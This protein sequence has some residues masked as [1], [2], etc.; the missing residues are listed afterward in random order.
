MS[1]TVT[2]AAGTRPRS[3]G[4]VTVS[5]SRRGGLALRS[6]VGLAFLA[7]LWAILGWAGALD[8]MVVPTIGATFSDLWTLVG[9]SDFWSALGTTLESTF[10]GLAAGL[11][12]ALPLAVL[13]ADHRWLRRALMPTV[14][15][16]RPI[17]PIVILPIAVLIIGS[18][19]VTPLVLVLQGVL[20]LLLIQASYGVASIDP[21]VIETAR[22]FRV[23][24]IRMLL[25]VKLPAAAPVI[26]SG[27]RLAATSAFSVSIMVELVGGQKGLGQ[28]LSIAQSGNQIARVY[29]IS[30]ATGLLGLIIAWI[31]GRLQRQ[32]SPWFGASAS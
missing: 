27:L 16:L 17:P 2:T 29:S 7:L 19:V 31:F 21:V 6:C 22:S 9:L 3:W 26:L 1:L 11:V 18:G 30:L 24:R 32:I 20:W 10:L 14:E 28:S 15:S 4:R 23:D 25:L 13:I 5:F 8:P 12:I